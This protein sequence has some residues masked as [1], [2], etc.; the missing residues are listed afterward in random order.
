MGEPAVAARGPT[1]WTAALEALPDGVVIFDAEWTV[2]FINRAGAALVGRPADE[3]T[4]RSIW[5][6]LTEMSGT[7]F[8]SFL[9][10]ARGAGRAVTWRGFYA[11]ADRWLS[12]TAVLVG[13][14]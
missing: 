14:L 13:R 10:H 1:A 8:H 5:V 4:G 9:L 3:L 12:A 2:C 7:I 6:A 11:P